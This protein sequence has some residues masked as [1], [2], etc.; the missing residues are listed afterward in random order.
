MTLSQ[1]FGASW[2]RSKEVLKT[3]PR[4]QEAHEGAWEGGGVPVRQLRERGGG[5]GVLHHVALLL[6]LGVLCSSVLSSAGFSLRISWTRGGR[7]PAGL[8]IVKTK[9][10]FYTLER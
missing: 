10:N 4:F 6:L 2:P 3:P 9:Q 8:V 5:D 1:V 7:Q